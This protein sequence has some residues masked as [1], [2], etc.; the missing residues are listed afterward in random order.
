MGLV[1]GAAIWKVQTN[2]LCYG[3][4][5]GFDFV[6]IL[7]EIANPGHQILQRIQFLVSTLFNT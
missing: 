3:G 5:P 2:P 6:C 4:T 7:I 1:P